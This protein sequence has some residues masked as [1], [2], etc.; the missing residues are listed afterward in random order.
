MGRTIAVVSGKGGVGKTTVVAGLSRALAGL[1]LSV[2]AVDADIG[3]N[4]LDLCLGVEDRVVFD[5]TD[6]MSGKCRLVQAIIKDDRLDN[7][8]VLASSRNLQ[9]EQALS[10]GEII[11]KLA[12]IFDYVL[13]DAPAGSGEGFLR[14]LNS[15]AEV[16]LVATPH[17]S[18]IRDASKIF[19][20]VASEQGKNTMLVIN[21]LRGDMV[22]SGK[23]MGHN[24]ICALVG[25]RLLG[26]VPE[27]DGYSAENS[28][29]LLSSSDPIMQS[30][31]ILAQNL[32]NDTQTI[33]NYTAKYTG[34]VGFLRRK[35]RNI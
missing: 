2:C 30:M 8:Y 17:I 28:I 22:A 34:I 23:M 1:G 4:N 7:L 6:C 21:R 13:V 24:D 19:G 10:F 11:K 12:T 16:I 3:L 32:V 18:A 14:A 20:M 33:Y 31:D 25:A 27:S 35:L 9:V 15:C 26:V 29:N 5:L